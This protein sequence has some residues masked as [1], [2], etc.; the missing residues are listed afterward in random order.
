MNCW[1]APPAAKAVSCRCRGSRERRGQAPWKDMLVYG[2]P[3]AQLKA[4]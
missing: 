4:F 1:G 3:V 2:K